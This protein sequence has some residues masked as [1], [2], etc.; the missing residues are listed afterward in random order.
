MA[1][2]GV[3]RFVSRNPV[4]GV[5]AGERLDPYF[6]GLWESG[7]SA[8][9]FESDVVAAQGRHGIVSG[10]AWS[11]P[12]D[13]QDALVKVC[14]GPSRRTDLAVL[15]AVNLWRTLT[16]EQVAAIV[17]RPGLAG[18]RPASIHRL[19]SAGLVDVG[20][21]ASIAR[22]SQVPALLRPAAR[23][24]WARLE[25]LVTFDDWVGVT[26]GQPWR[27]GSQ[28]DRHNVLLAELALR[29]AE[30]SPVAMVFG[31]QLA[32]VGRMAVPGVEV[33]P[34]SANLAGDAVVVRGDGLRIVVELTV[35]TSNLERKAERW[36][37]LLASD[38]GRMLAVCF[39][40]APHP[41][42][43][44]GGRAG[45]VRRKVAAAANGTVGQQLAGVPQRMMVARWGDWFPARHAV[46]DGFV[47]LR[48][49]RPSGVGERRWRPVHM[50]DPF[51][52]AGPQGGA[53]L[54][55]LAN[56]GWLYGV[57]HW[58]RGGRGV[59]PSVAWAAR[60]G[61]RPFPRQEGVPDPPQVRAARAAE[62]DGL[63][64]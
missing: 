7:S 22:S 31:E 48:A 57:P 60:H 32:A 54:A 53:G 16:F 34:W 9:W 23:G 46:S 49:Y 44:D 42:L 36:A 13:R 2:L 45:E 51:D 35:S 64:G 20:V 39:V 29:A 14:S 41:S 47:S 50:L 27:R 58:L 11:R 1:D 43:P 55:V 12:M 56:A 18:R 38:A 61:V 6:D 28:H 26:A 52:L 63:W 8:A 62:L 59:S 37:G 15:A 4:E 17:G 5:R 25:G 3:D 40:H 30:V 24:D 19:W 10:G 21:P 33:S